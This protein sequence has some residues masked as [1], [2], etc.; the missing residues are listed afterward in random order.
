MGLTLYDSCISVHFLTG[1]RE[2]LLP[3][4]LITYF[5]CCANRSCQ[6]IEENPMFTPIWFLVGLN[7]FQSLRNAQWSQCD[8]TSLGHGPWREESLVGSAILSMSYEVEGP[9]EKNRWS[10][11]ATTQKNR[12]E[13]AGEVAGQKPI[14]RFWFVVKSSVVCFSFGYSVEM[15]KFFFLFLSNWFTR[16]REFS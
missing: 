13:T 16:P 11:W 3:V 4:K 10:P 7:T 2:N 6:E 8:S 12:C 1:F 9:A 15:E 14:N 5:C